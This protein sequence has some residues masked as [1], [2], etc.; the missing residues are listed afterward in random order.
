MLQHLLHPQNAFYSIVDKNNELVAYCSFGKDG[1]VSGGDY[2]EEALDVGMG[3]RPNLTGQRKGVEYA[4]AVLEFASSLLQPKALRVTIAA[5]NKRAIRVW[6][7]LKFEHRQSFK[8]ESD[9]IQ[10]IVLVR[11]DCCNSSL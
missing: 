2:R 11:V 3:I 7:K 10:F 1:Q 6:Q 9:G 5:F 4:K 8:R